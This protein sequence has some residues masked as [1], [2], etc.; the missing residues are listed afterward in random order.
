MVVIQADCD[1][2]AS[3]EPK[4][5]ELIIPR[6]Q[7]PD[8]IAKL[9]WTHAR[10]SDYYRTAKNLPDRFEKPGTRLRCSYMHNIRL[11]QLVNYF[12]MFSLFH[13]SSAEAC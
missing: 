4:P 13:V 5:G 12:K 1:Q 10:T 8:H 2:I 6:E 3:E 7:I 11:Q 9:K